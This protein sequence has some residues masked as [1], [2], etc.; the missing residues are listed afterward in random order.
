MK[1]TLI[2][3]ALLFSVLLSGCANKGKPE[4]IKLEP[5]YY[6]SEDGWSWVLLEEDRQFKFNRH[7]AMSYMPMGKYY[8]EENKLVLYV[9][10]NEKYVFTIREDGSLERGL[11]TIRKNG[12]LEYG[13]G[14]LYKF[15]GDKPGE[16]LFVN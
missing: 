2:L 4:Q 10:D 11:V 16:L 13:S 1:K 9:D 3:L 6:T 15:T 5:G 7:S 8:I 14:T 12:S